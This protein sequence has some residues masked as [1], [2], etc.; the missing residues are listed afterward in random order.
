ML[1]GDPGTVLYGG[2]VLF[3]GT[4]SLSGGDFIVERVAYTAR[5]IRTVRVTIGIGGRGIWKYANDLSQSCFLRM[6]RR[7]V[8]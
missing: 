4:S 1:S 2:L 7:S 6:R 5:E 8:Q 3:A